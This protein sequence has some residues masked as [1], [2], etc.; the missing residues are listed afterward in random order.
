M[1]GVWGNTSLLSRRIVMRYLKSENRK[2][3]V[4]TGTGAILLSLFILSLITGESGFGIFATIL[5]NVIL[6][7]KMPDENSFFETTFLFALIGFF[8]AKYLVIYFVSYVNSIIGVSTSGFE[9]QL[10]VNSID[11]L[12]LAG[13]F[14]L[15]FHFLDK[16]TKN[17][18]DNVGFIVPR[19]LRLLMFLMMLIICTFIVS[20]IQGAL[21]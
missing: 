11:L 13:G 17:F 16:F 1:I 21:M 9:A 2:I 7:Y 12:I 20:L 19:L 6:A 4:F 5:I 18:N 14:Y 10:F 3:F 15:I 8:I